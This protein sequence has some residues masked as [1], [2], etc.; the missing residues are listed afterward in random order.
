[1]ED[2]DNVR[3]HQLDLD[4][5]EEDTLFTINKKYAENY[6]S[7]K[8]A[9]EITAL[10][11][12]YGNLKDFEAERMEKMRLRMRKYGYKVDDPRLL[13]SDSSDSEDSASEEDEVGELATPEIHVQVL[14]TL[15][16][17]RQRDQR[18]YDTQTEFFTEEQMNEARTKWEE[19]QKALKESEKP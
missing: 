1:M 5:D 3:V 11:E 10:K 14:K 9:E 6:E 8:R 17:I 19:K 12:K 18:I 13:E 16:A 2:T 15:G 7:R 4:L